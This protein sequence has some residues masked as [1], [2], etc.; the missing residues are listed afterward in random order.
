MSIGGST[1]VLLATEDDNLIA[2]SIC[3]QH[4]RNHDLQLRSLRIESDYEVYANA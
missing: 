2:L 3:L 1:C 4:K